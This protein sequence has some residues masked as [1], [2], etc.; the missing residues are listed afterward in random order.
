LILNKR[1]KKKKCD[2]LFVLFDIELLKIKCLLLGFLPLSTA[3]DTI[4]LL[5]Q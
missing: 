4:I 2:M 5:I 3:H 1:N